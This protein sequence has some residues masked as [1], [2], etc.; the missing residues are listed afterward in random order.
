MFF[1]PWGLEN[2]VVAGG[3]Y[4]QGEGDYQ[5]E[6]VDSALK[7][8]KDMGGDATLLVANAGWSSD[9]YDAIVQAARERG[10]NLLWFSSIESLTRYINYGRYR[11]IDPITSFYVFAHGTDSGTGNYAITFGL[12][13]N[14]DEQLRWYISDISEINRAAFAINVVSYFYT[15]R[16]GND[17][18]NGNFA[19]K[20]AE[21]TG[22][23]TWAYSGWN[24][25]TDYS[26]ILGT[27]GERHGLGSTE[28]EIWKAARESTGSIIE[29]PGAAW[30][31]PRAT[32]FS[33]KKKF[34]P[35]QF[36]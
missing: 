4:H 6:F 23:E 17:F 31:L 29:K 33:S 32:S 27:W 15:C 1:D 14:K 3:A 21:K 25:R 7:Q 26:D 35:P 24:G 13:T 16:T 8:I 10:I 18:D 5:F 19:K 20:W 30:R 22:G 34:M 12:Y 36:N 28:F 9:Q 2:I 11:T